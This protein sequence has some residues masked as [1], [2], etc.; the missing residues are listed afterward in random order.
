MLT[1]RLALIAAAFAPFKSALAA[2][3]TLDELL[4]DH[5]I[6]GVHASRDHDYRITHYEAHKR[7]DSWGCA[8]PPRIIHASGATPYEA[9]S[10]LVEKLGRS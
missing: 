7:L 9:V 2:K 6:N 4:V 5:E 8:S 3:P 1:R 10:N